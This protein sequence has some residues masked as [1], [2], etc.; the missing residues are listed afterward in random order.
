MRC[1]CERRSCTRREEREG[2]RA[3]RAA[4]ATCCNIVV[5]INTDGNESRTHSQS[6]Q[7]IAG[8][9]FFL[10]F[11]VLS[12]LMH[13]SP[14]LSAAGSTSASAKTRFFIILKSKRTK[15]TTLSCVQA[16][17]GIAERSGVSETAA[18]E[19]EWELGEGS[20]R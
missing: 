15:G 14:A 7:Y 18:A 1:K 11:F 6:E 2:H 4:R 9:P 20:R 17:D 3:A 10:Q 19:E 16:A 8:P 5:D 13:T 12:S